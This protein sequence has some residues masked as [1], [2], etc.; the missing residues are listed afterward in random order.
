MKMVNK[1]ISKVINKVNNKISKIN[2]K[3]NK[4]FKL[5]V[6]VKLSL[7]LKWLPLKVQLIQIKHNKITVKMAVKINLNV[8]YVKHLSNLKQ[9]YLNISE[10]LVMQL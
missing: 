8:W 9:S 1:V 3:I 10:K 2:N 7:L 6:I 4:I 5:K